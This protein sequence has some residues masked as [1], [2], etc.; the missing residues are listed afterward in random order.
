RYAS[1]LEPFKEFPLNLPD[2]TGKHKEWREVMPSLPLK[3][4]LSLPH[5]HV[6]NYKDKPISIKIQES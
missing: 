5:A 1:E 4:K 6:S 3:S 2:Y